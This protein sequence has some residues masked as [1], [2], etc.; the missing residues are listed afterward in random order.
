MVVLAR[1]AHPHAGVRIVVGNQ[2]HL[3][4]GPLQAAV[5][6]QEATD[7]G[8]RCAGCQRLLLVIALERT[9]GG[10]ASRAEDGVS[11]VEIEERRRGDRDHQIRAGAG[12]AAHRVVRWGCIRLW[13]IATSATPACTPTCTKGNQV[14]TR[15]VT[16]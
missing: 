11:F 5:E 9:V 12:G 1:Q 10:G 2:G 3:D 8:E 13:N 16:M 4:G 15:G 7:E 14:V 6:C